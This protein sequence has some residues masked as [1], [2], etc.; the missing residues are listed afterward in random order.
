[1]AIIKFPGCMAKDLS[2][3]RERGLLKVENSYVGTLISLMIVEGGTKVA[4]A[5]NVE[6]GIS[7]N[8]RKGW[9]FLEKTSS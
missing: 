7:W 3:E 9:Y 2:L 4:K 5:I 1:M 8:E 6:V